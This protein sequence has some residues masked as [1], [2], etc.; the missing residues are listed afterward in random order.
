MNEYISVESFIE[1]IKADFRKQADAGLIDEASIYRD[2]ELGLKR[3]GNDIKELQETIVH[4]KN[5]K[6]VLTSNI[7]S[8][9]IA[10]LY[11]PLRD[12]KEKTWE[13]NS[14]QK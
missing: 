10:D 11:Q 13:K 14:L 2:I 8:L 6:V 4:V 3:F 12:S 7:S 5:G 9:Y 1:E